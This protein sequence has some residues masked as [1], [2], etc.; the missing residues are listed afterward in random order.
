MIQHAARMNDYTNTSTYSRQEFHTLELY[1]LKYFKWCMSHPSVAH[2]MDYYLY[3][4]LRDELSTLTEWET[5]VLENHMQ[6]FSTYF[7]EATL[8]G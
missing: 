1:I 7:M 6:E 4:S 3:I 2:F 5:C 8:R